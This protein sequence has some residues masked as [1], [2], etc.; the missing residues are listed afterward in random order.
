MLGF[1]YN[2]QHSSKMKVGYAPKDR[3]RGEIMANY[4][5]LDSERNWVPGGDWL[6]EHAKS[7]TMELECWYE[8]L[9]DRERN[10]IARWLDRRTAG[11]LIFDERPHARY[12]VRPTKAIEPRDY[13]SNVGGRILHSGLF[14]IT[15]TAYWPFA[16]LLYTTNDNAP[17]EALN[18]VDLLPESMVPASVHVDGGTLYN[19]LFVVYNPGTEQGHSII[20]F[21]GS[22]GS[23]DL[24]ITNSTTGD[25]CKIKAGTTTSNDDYY[26]IDSKNMRFELVHNGVHSLAWDKHEGGYIEFAPNRI[27]RDNI[28]ISRTSGSNVITGNGIFE[29]DMVGDYIY[30]NATWNRITAY[31]DENTVTCVANASATGSMQSKVISVNRMQVTK[32]NDANVTLLSVECKPEVR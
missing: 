15:F 17:I 21:A 27:K 6:G 30:Y 8:Y 4:D 22:T 25:V 26:E 20:R 23:G 7:R 11:W 32:A 19:T 31:T 18:E 5:V 24:T 10:E 14:T 1:T 28:T 16:E 2:G 3:A 13:P 9:T 12:Y 29:S